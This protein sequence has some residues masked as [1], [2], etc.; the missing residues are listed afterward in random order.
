MKNSIKINNK[1]ST[2]SFLIIALITT[3]SLIYLFNDKVYTTNH[4][5]TVGSIVI[6]PREGVQKVSQNIQKDITQTTQISKDVI[7]LA[8]NIFFE[9][10]NID[11]KEKIRIVNVTLNRV[12]SG[13]YPSSVCEVVYQD[14]QFSWTNERKNLKSI[15]NKS[16]VER[17]AWEDSIKIAQNAINK[18]YPD[19]TNGALYYHTHQVK[20]RWSVKKKKT[21]DSKWHKYYK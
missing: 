7:C 19:I 2:K 6:T 4:I 9:G 13:I 12:K 21:V 3:L 11:I 18:N 16:S 1:R 8:K 10:R 15:V 5:D 17:Q 20:P 14:S